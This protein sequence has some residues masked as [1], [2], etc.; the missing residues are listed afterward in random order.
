MNS[1]DVDDNEEVVARAI[2]ASMVEE[3][4]AELENKEAEEIGELVEVSV[5][6]YHS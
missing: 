1:S 3:A 4:R 6:F 5:Q 2:T